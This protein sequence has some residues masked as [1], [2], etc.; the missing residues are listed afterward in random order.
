MRGGAVWQLV[1][2][3]PNPGVVVNRYKTPLGVY[4]W[5]YTRV[6]FAKERLNNR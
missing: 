2:H 5:L 3:N 1:A 6:L 4:K